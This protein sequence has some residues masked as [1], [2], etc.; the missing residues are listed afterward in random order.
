MMGIGAEIMG[1]GA[2]IIMVDDLLG[3]GARG[4]PGRLGARGNSVLD[5]LGV[6]DD[7][8]VVSPLRDGGALVETSFLGVLLASLS[9][10][11]PADPD[12]E[13]LLLTL[14]RRPNV[15]KKVADPL[16]TA[17]EIVDFGGGTGGI[18]GRLP[19]FC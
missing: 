10:P 14:A 6:D 4:P 3:R 11:S 8:G 17:D 13:P 15:A 19:V 18:L 16:F 2:P 7:G 5:L 9:L 12:C 1:F